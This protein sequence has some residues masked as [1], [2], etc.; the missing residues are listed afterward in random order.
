MG[1]HGNLEAGRPKQNQKKTEWRVQVMVPA[2]Q[3]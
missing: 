2:P 1:I 3:M